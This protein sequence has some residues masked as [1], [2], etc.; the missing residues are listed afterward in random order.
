MN[1]EVDDPFQPDGVYI[2]IRVNLLH[3]EMLATLCN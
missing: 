1:S 2:F 3:L